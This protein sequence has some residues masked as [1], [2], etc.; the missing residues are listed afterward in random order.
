MALTLTDGTG[1]Y[2]SAASGP[3]T[4][5]F[6]WMA[7]HYFPSVADGVDLAF[8]RGNGVRSYLYSS[9][10]IYFLPVSLYGSSVLSVNTW[11]HIA[12]TKNG[13]AHE[14]FLDGVSDGSTS[15]SSTPDSAISMNL[16]GYDGAG[17]RIS[18]FK[19]FAAV[20]TA[21]EIYQ[22]KNFH[23]PVRTLN[24]DRWSHFETPDNANFRDYSGTGAADWIETGTLTQGNPG[25]PITWRKGASRIFVPAAATPPA[26]GRA[27]FL[28]LLGVA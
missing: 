26:T 13:N 24:L 23:V 3:S 16:H 12:F 7:W 28:P 10:N 21:D 22:E 27:K 4:D 2:L 18:S 17:R 20:L 14:I 8:Q 11:Y 6:T 15:A 1:N 9:G 19:H 5:P 25:P